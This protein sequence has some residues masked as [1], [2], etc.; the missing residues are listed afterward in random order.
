MPNV[1]S[2]HPETG[3]LLRYYC[4]CQGNLVAVAMKYAADAYCHKEA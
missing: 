3:E 2:I 4:S 1:N